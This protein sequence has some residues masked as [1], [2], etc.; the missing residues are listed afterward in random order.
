LLASSHI[1][2]AEQGAKRK[3]APYGGYLSA[4]EDS[5]LMPYIF[6]VGHFD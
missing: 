1:V 6:K 3:A 2:A 4:D 5:F